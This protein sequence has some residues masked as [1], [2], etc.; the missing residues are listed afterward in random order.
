MTSLTE[1]GKR[2]GRSATSCRFEALGHVSPLPTTAAATMYHDKHGHG[3]DAIPTFLNPAAGQGDR[4]VLVRAARTQLISESQ[5][6][7]EACSCT[8]F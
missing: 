3:N 6:L 5:S 1:P 7:T 2:V 8:S 4:V